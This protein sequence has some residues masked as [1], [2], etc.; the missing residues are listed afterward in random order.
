M[1]T[2]NQFSRYSTGARYNIVLD[3]GTYLFS[4]PTK[5]GMLNIYVLYG[6]IVDVLIA[7]NS[8]KPISIKASP[9]NKN[10]LKHY[11]PKLYF[12]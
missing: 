3:L 6:F 1:L 7:T 4:V 2:L 11:H 10:L 5:K 8:K 9:E 12:N